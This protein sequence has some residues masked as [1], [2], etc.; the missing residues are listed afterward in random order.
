LA[1][2]LRKRGHQVDGDNIVKLYT[3]VCHD[4]VKNNNNN[5]IQACYV[6]AKLY[7][8][9]FFVPKNIRASTQTYK[10]ACDHGDEVACLMQYSGWIFILPPTLLHIVMFVLV[11]FF[12]LRCFDGTIR[13]IRR[14]IFGVNPTQANFNIHVCLAFLLTCICILLHIFSTHEVDYYST[15]RLPEV[16]IFAVIIIGIWKRIG[17]FFPIIYSVFF[18]LLSNPAQ[19][20]AS[21]M[22]AAKDYIIGG[23]VDL[24][25]MSLQTDILQ[26]VQT[27][28]SIISVLIIVYFMPRLVYWMLTNTEIHKLFIPNLQE[29]VELEVNQKRLKIS[30]GSVLC[31]IPWTLNVKYGEQEYPALYFFKG[32][33]VFTWTYSLGTCLLDEHT[34]LE[35][36]THDKLIVPL[37]GRY[38]SIK[39]NGERFEKTWLTYKNARKYITQYCLL[40]TLLLLFLLYLSP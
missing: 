29:E 9:G 33:L 26:R 27:P 36:I 2:L 28:L 38:I 35:V 7:K 25:L 39:I 10:Q 15:L 8:E 23:R 16:I 21:S 14:D 20:V 18:I 6:L 22:W 30:I 5:Y 4:E 11:F 32:P 17:F 34:E 1:E 12:L 31:V 13:W 24:L 19:R 37:I 3:K 40:T